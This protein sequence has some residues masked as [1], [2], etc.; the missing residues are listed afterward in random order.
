[1]PNA[2]TNHAANVYSPHESA[3]LG[4]E[5]AKRAAEHA[6]FGI[7]LDIEGTNPAVKEYF[8]PLLP[9]EI[10]AVQAQ[11]GNGKT[12]F[13]NWWERQ[14]AAQ[15]KRQERDEIIIHVSLEESIE[16]MAFQDYGRILN[17]RPADFARGQFTDWARMQ[18]AMSQIDGVPVWRIGDSAERPDDAPELYLSNIYRAIRELVEGKITG[19]KWKPA[20]VIVD[21]LQ[22][23]PVDPE[24]KQATR[25]N[26]RRLQV[27]QDVFRLREM[28]THLQAP[29][30]VPLQ[31]KQELQGA[32]YPFKIPGV[33]DGLETSTIATR[34][35]RMI[36]LWMPKMSDVIGSTVS[37]KDGSVNF[38]VKEDQCFLK[39]N[40]QRGGL[41]SGRVW[42]LRI[43]Y[44][45][46]EYY[47]VYKK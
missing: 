29:I 47:D 17:Q 18:W 30:I 14:I 8:A 34:F 24:V 23:L 4:Y 44:Q 1:M 26:Q 41:P 36:S 19:D 32:N 25:D 33:Y 38:Q 6:Q 42:E 35:D 46:H 39:V 3:M 43:D 45:K 28:T 10:C 31:A 13:T 22:A 5:Q 2:K 21:Y 11:T 37:S 20:V 7:E 27:A 40:K 15:L 12:Y 9:W 16:A